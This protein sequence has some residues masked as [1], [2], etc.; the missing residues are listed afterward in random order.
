MNFRRTHRTKFLTRITLPLLAIGML[1][2]ACNRTSDLTDKTFESTSSAVTTPA[3]GAG[4]TAGAG[5]AAGAGGQPTT[6]GEC[7]GTCIQNHC[8]RTGSGF[9]INASPGGA[10]ALQGVFA[11]LDG[12]GALEAVFVNQLGEDIRSFALDPVGPKATL[13]QKLMT[14]RGVTRPAVGDINGD[15]QA[16]LV[17]TL[18]ETITLDPLDRIRIYLGIAGGSFD[19]AFT[20]FEQAGTPTGPVLLDFDG[21]GD[22]DIY[23]HTK[24]CQLMRWG[25]GGG[26]FSAPECLEGTDSMSV[27]TVIHGGFGAKDALLLID[28][29]SLYVRNWI[30]GNKTKTTRIE[31]GTELV[32]GSG[33]ADIDGDG[34]DDI[35]VLTQET[36][37]HPNTV[38]TFLRTAEADVTQCDTYP[39]PPGISKLQS[40]V[41]GDFD[42]DGV[43]DLLALD[44]TNES[45]TPDSPA[46]F[47]SVNYV[48]HGI[49]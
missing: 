42:A 16:D 47:Q 32:A 46:Y 31:M 10:E 35:L 30:G 8:C 7:D 34:D 17:V 45:K 14:G 13:L 48:F 12:K 23:L 20:E 19:T 11:Q 24:T 18:S 22:L 26:T 2:S 49:K 44:R 21:D 40:P 27:T 4:G 39:T 6:C 36:S 28:G 5:G 29:G 37:T 41:L 43:P 1:V 3:T 38:Y 15:G 33:V 9:E 25:L